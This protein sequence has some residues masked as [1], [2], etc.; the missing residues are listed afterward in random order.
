M[1]DLAGESFFD[2]L[3]PEDAPLYFQGWQAA[4]AM[5]SRFEDEARVRGA[6]GIYRWFLARSIP[7]RSEDGKIARWYG[8][9]IDIEEQHRAQQNLTL[10]QEESGASTRV[11]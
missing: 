2:I 4:L 1:A 7:Q 3:H 11:T 8:I 10:A 6:D 5:G 9:H